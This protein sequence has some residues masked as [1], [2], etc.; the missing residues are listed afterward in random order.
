MSDYPVNE[1]F[2]RVAAEIYK[3]KGTLCQ[4]LNAAASCLTNDF[5]AM[6]RDCT[7]EP[8]KQRLVSGTGKHGERYALQWTNDGKT[9]IGSVTLVALEFAVCDLV[10]A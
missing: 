4:R 2:K 6:F 10:G 5:Q 7:F 3:D 8:D 1:E 9:R